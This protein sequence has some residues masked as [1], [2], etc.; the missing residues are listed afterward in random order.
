MK[1]VL[2]SVGEIILKE[3]NLKVKVQIDKCDSKELFIS[4]DEYI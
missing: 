1:E 4:F 3:L 2:F